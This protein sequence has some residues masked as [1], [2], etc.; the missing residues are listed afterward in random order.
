A[1]V[2]GGLAGAKQRDFTAAAQPVAGT[3]GA[4]LDAKQRDF[5]AAAQCA[6]AAGGRG[7]A[8]AKQRD[9]TAAAR[10]VAADGAGG[11]AGAEH[12]HVVTTTDVRAK[13]G[14]LHR[15]IPDHSSAEGQGWQGP[16][17]QDLQP[18]REL[19]RRP[20]ASSRTLRRRRA[21]EPANQGTDHGNLFR[22][23]G[24][25]FRTRQTVRPLAPRPNGAVAVLPNSS[26]TTRTWMPP[27]RITWSPR[28]W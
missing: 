8:G 23:I 12:G 24:F 16:A 5:T 13:Q 1:A 15:D 27:W 26:S 19:R 14:G 18:G 6:E 17:F 11:L 9:F 20:G 3:N 21:P 10:S 4:G 28:S 22:E 25:A 7:L 2:G